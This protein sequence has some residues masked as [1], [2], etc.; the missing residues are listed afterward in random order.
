MFRFDANQAASQNRGDRREDEKQP[1]SGPASS[2]SRPVSITMK[3]WETKGK[4][5]ALPRRFKN[6]PP[7]E[8]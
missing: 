8:T 7:W 1:C 2:H 4:I 5:Y 6:C 3:V